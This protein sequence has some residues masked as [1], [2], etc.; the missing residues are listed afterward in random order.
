MNRAFTLTAGFILFAA[1]G[2]VLPAIYSV[3]TR[4]L[5][6]MDHAK[7]SQVF[8]TLAKA[9]TRR[10][11]TGDRFYYSIEFKWDG[12]KYRIPVEVTSE[13]YHLS[14]EGQNMEAQIFFDMGRPYVRLPGNH[15][16][17]AGRPGLFYLG[18]AGLVAGILL[19]ASSV[20]ARSR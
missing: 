10:S 19:L 6:A 5:R 14:K 18:A 11:P 8:V 13:F 9:Q 4:D 7:G 17:P 2:S 15:I 3:Y 16:H 1:F 12:T 20:L